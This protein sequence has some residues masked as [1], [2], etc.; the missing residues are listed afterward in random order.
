MVQTI[1]AFW[2]FELPEPVVEA[3]TQLQTELARIFPH[4]RWV[5]SANLHL[6]LHFLGD[7]HPSLVEKPR[8]PSCPWGK[9]A[10]FPVG[11]NLELS[12]CPLPAIT[13][14]YEKF[15]AIQPQP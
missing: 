2:A 12:G 14:F 3:V 10:L 6:T 9:L 8:L 4:L 13:P 1:R 11:L 15:M 5:N 7:I